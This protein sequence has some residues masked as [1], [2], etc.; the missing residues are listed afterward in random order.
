[1]ANLR[2][3]RTAVVFALGGA[4]VSCSTTREPPN[5]DPLKGQ[6]R[7]YVES[8]E[9]QRDIA[10]VAGRARTWIEQRVAKRAPGERLAV[11]FDLDETLFL[12]WPYLRRNDFG[13]VEAVWQAW[14]EAAEAPPSEPVREV[15]RAA[16]RS[17][18]VA[19]FITGRFESQRAATERNLRAI[20]CSEYAALICKP[21]GESRKSADI[22][23]QARRQL[24]E[25]G[26]TLIANI[27][28]Q[29][30]DLV[31][32]FAERTFKLPA[33]FYLTE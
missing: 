14:I 30:S 5:L 11:V 6:I 12:N 8:G 31:G 2:W 18:V 10:A 22:K 27:G 7:T 3:L 16:V 25:S 15:Y 26:W 9:Y 33:P 1:M 29:Q 4:G 17:G 19:I 24:Q 20:N 21:D 28:D 13:Y 23:T 32:G